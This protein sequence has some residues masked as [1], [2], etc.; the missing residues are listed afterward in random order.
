MAPLIPSFERQHFV[1]QHA[2]IRNHG[3]LTLLNNTLLSARYLFSDLL[4]VCLPHLCN[5]REN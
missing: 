5:R 2:P 1:Q 3:A 4:G